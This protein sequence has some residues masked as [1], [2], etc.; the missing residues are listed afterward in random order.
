MQVKAGRLPEEEARFHRPR[1]AIAVGVADF[2]AEAPIEMSFAKGERMR[3]LD[4]VDN[5]VTPV[6]WMMASKVVLLPT[7]PYTSRPAVALL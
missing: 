4:D 5:I 3:V 7:P 1:M 6:G 2:V